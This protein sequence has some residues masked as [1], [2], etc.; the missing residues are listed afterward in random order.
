MKYRVNRKHLVKVKRLKNKAG[1]RTD[2]LGTPAV[3]QPNKSQK[4]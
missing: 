4:S 3:K 1:P 2:P